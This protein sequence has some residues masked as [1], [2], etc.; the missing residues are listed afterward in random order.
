MRKPPFHTFDD[1]SIGGVREPMLELLGEVAALKQIVA[2]Q[3]DKI[4]RLKGG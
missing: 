2:G 4:A 3:R 1:L